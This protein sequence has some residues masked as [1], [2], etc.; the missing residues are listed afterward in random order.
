MKSM[1]WRLLG[2]D[3][4][5]DK[6]ESLS[7]PVPEA[8]RE[9]M[10][11]RPEIEFVLS[12]DRHIWPSVF[13]YPR[14]KGFPEIGASLLEVDSDCDGYLWLGLERMRQRVEEGHREA[15]LIAVEL[16]APADATVDDFPSPL[17]YSTPS[18]MG[19]PESSVVLG[20]DVAD[21]GNWSGLSNCG[22]GIEERAALRS[23][24]QGRL[25]DFGLLDAERDALEFRELADVRV[26]EH[27]PFWVYRH[28][29]LSAV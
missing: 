17:I 11:L 3:A 5:E 19:V 9:Q 8:V 13:R 12:V 14:P 18:P 22:Y 4:R 15:V 21:S 25:N 2:F 23:K 28:S 27:A 6:E 26:P 10:F 1:R 20:Y 24:W 7:T 16:L 29:R